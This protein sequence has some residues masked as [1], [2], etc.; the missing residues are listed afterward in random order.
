MTMLAENFS[1]VLDSRFRK[2]FNDDQTQRIEKSMIPFLYTTKTTDKNYEKMSGIGGGSDVGLF[3]G[4]LDYDDLGQLYDKTTYFAERAKGMKIQRK[5]YDDSEFGIMDQRPL[6]LSVDIARTRE[7]M[8]ASVFNGAFTG[9]GGADSVSL[10]STAHPYSPTDATT[11]SNSGTA[12]LNPVNI[13][14]VRRVGHT[15]IFNDRG[16]LVE[17][18]YDTILCTVYKEEMAYEIISSAGKVETPNN[19]V[20]FHKGRYKLSVWD[21]LSSSYPWFMIDSTLASMF[22]IWWTRIAPEFNQERDFDTYVAKWSTYFRE[23]PD[24]Y[25]WRFIYGN[26]ATS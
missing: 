15:S 9:T 23:Y 24:F 13:E 11:M 18:N 17:V 6:N 5:L 8:A 21:R 7:K 26:N 20:N 22:L 16:E 4:S 2:I 14:A 25:D 10:C 12:T 3:T 19:N 1:D